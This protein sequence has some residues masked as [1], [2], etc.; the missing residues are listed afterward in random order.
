LETPIGFGEK[1]ANVTLRKMFETYANVR[2]IRGFQG[3]QTPYS[4]R[5]LDFVVVRENVEDLYA[6]IEYKPTANI[7]EGLKVITRKGCEKIARFAFELARSENR[8]SVHCATKSNIL[9]FTEGLLKAVFEEVAQDYPEI[10][11]KHIII[12][13]CAHQLVV[14]PEIFEVIVT[15]NLNG[16]IISDLASG[17][18]GGLGVAPGANIG[19]E[20]AI[21]EAVHGSAPKYAGLNVI[22]PMAVILSAVM[23]LRYM[24]EFEG[25]NTIE[26]ALAVTLKE[27]KELT[28]DLVG[29]EKA[30]T[31]SKFTDRII[32][33]FGRPLE[34]WAPRSYKKLITPSLKDG[35][36][37]AKE[38]ICGI[39]LYIKSLKSPETLGKH[40]EELTQESDFTLQMISNRG[41]KV[42][43]VTPGTLPDTVEVFQCRFLSKAGDVQNEE[44]ISLLQKIGAQYEW[45]SLYKLT[46]I[47]DKEGFTKA[48][49]EG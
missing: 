3:I 6:G 40:L 39:D 21:F 20:V 28:K 9:K 1:S 34:N 10:E 48:Q 15:T 7:A 24:G 27:G 42:Y 2:P 18:V 49:G 11:A 5:H 32:Q 37:P 45:L 26:Q 47:D 33:N 13:N 4:N 31:T 12:D 8:Q 19:G 23:M 25:A 30:A 46:L 41:L 14:K 22:N 43:P 44:I 36:I 29:E 16:D 38:T 35:L 17:L